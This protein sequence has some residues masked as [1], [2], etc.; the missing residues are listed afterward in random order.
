MP[1][2]GTLQTLLLACAPLHSPYRAAQCHRQKM[3]GTEVAAA[4][5]RSSD[6]LKTVLDS[7]LG[8]YFNHSVDEVAEGTIRGVSVDTRV[9]LASFKAGAVSSRHVLCHS[10]GAS[11]ADFV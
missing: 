7:V 10:L 9:A 3:S 5:I 2:Y 1:G 11:D 6:Q 4:Q 8:N